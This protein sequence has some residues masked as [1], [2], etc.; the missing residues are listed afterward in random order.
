ML[1]VRMAGSKEM[2]KQDKNDSVIANPLET[3]GHVDERAGEE[4]TPSFG[5]G[6]T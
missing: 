4:N 3:E 1:V 2:S 5:W 6:T